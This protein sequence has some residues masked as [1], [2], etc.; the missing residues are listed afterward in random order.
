MTTLPGISLQYKSYPP[1]TEVKP[2]VRWVGG[3]RWAIQHVG[4]GVHQALCDSGGKFIEPFCGGAALA[5]WLGWG[6]TILSDKCRPLAT[7]YSE[8]IRDPKALAKALHKLVAR[9]IDAE[10][11]YAIRAER[12]S[13]GAALAAWCL[14]LNKTNFNGL[15]RENKS[16]GFNVPY[17]K[18]A[19]PAFP[20][21]EHL[22]AWGKQAHEWEVICGD[23]AETVSRA[24]SGD[25]IFADPPYFD[26]TGG[27]FSGYVQGGWTIPNQVR[28]VEALSAARSRGAKVIATDGGSER[29]REVYASAGFS[30]FPVAEQH[31]VSARVEGRK[32]TRAWLTTSDPGL[33]A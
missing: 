32:R 28:L 29:T 1:P 27:G 7:L 17:G 12:P 4:L 8:A 21:D 20:S 6:R 24:G 19:A 30:L 25:V 9:G 13:K 15:W 5:S 33:V 10:T 18:L 31:N 2:L 14:Y 11:Y 23:F 16:G 26:G 22:I 3:K